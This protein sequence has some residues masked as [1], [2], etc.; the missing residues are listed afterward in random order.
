MRGRMGTITTLSAVAVLM[1]WPT[2]AVAEPAD[3]S[4]QRVLRF[5]FPGV[6]IGTAEYPDGPTGAT[7]F[8][9]P[10]PAMVAVD[11]RGGSPGTINSDTLRLAYD[12]PFV[13]AITLAGGSSYG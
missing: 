10:K 8:H 4:P 9:F 5:D 2:A 7:V 13:D 11:V 1:A 3:G 12:E 6:H